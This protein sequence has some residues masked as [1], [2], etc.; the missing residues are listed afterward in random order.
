MDCTKP[1]A[2]FDQ[3]TIDVYNSVIKYPGKPT[4]SDVTI[5]IRDSMDGAVQ[6]LVGEQMQQQ[7][8]FANQASATAPG[9]F[10]FVTEIEELDGGNTA[11]TGED[12]T[13]L[14]TFTLGGC[15]IKSAAYDS[16]DY[17]NSGDPVTIKLTV[18]YDNALQD[19]GIGDTITRASSTS[20]I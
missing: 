20:S 11:G 18:C 13:V 10:K 6:E 12:P 14:T 4:W 15:W 5:T 17:K 19:T 2:Q 3:K 9:A 16:L 1:T 7:F 8:D